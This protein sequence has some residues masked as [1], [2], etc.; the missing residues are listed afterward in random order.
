VTEELAEPSLVDQI[1]GMPN[2]HA[3]ELFARDHA[4]HSIG[5]VYGDL[6]DF[7]RVNDRYGHPVGDQVLAEVARRV[8]D[9][10]PEGALAVRFGGDEFALLLPG[11]N[12][13]L[14]ED[15]AV[16]LLRAIQAPIVITV[17]EKELAHDQHISVGVAF[18]PPGDL[19][20]G[21]RAADEAM[22]EAKSRGRARAVCLDPDWQAT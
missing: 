2:R 20:A 11:E 19:P 8:T 16:A 21:L 7:L 3:A 12:L 22:Y 10:A 1:T 13:L 17:A 5:L 18:A 6:D 14:L 15:V 9:L 4:E